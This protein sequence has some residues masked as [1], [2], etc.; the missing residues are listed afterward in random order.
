MQ[1]HDDEAYMQKFRNTQK[2]EDKEAC[3]DK[4]R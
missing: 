3:E 4:M 2:H 1:K